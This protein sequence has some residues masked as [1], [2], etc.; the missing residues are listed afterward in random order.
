MRENYS[1]GSGPRAVVSNGPSIGVMAARLPKSR[2]DSSVPEMEVFSR[3]GQLLMVVGRPIERAAIL[4]MNA[5]PPKV[6]TG[7]K[8]FD[9]LWIDVLDVPIDGTL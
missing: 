4:P 1:A 9:E 6:G 2:L 8:Q 5:P 3:L 7:T